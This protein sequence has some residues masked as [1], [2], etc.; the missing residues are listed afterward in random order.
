M[1]NPL[2][3]KNAGWQATPHY[4]DSSYF[5]LAQSLSVSASASTATLPSGV[6]RSDHW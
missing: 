1:I 2:E 6:F 4:K 5:M 3:L